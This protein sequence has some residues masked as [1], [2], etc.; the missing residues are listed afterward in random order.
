MGTQFHMLI[1][2]MAACGKTHYLLKMLEED[3]KEYFDYVFIVCPTLLENSTYQNW[4]YLRE[5][6]VVFALP[7]DHDK[8]DSY[9]ETIVKFAKGTN[10]LMI[11]DN[12]AWPSTEG[13][14]GCP[15]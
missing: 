11:L 13:T 10:S 8:V 6:P 2:G 9:L 14:S 7:C 15:R 5:D 12:C 3:F 4:K 1:A